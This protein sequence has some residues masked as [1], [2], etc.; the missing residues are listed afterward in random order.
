MLQYIK[1]GEIETRFWASGDEGTTVIMLHGLE[2]SIEDW[3][4]NSS[5]LAQQHRVYALDLA[6]FGR[7]QKPPASFTFSYGAQF[8]NSFM[9]SRHIGQASICRR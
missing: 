6:G 5:A 9:E 1:A 8:V 3:Q 7:S 4:F 2:G